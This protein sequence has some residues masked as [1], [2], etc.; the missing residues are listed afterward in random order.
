MK[1][2]SRPSLLVLLGAAAVIALA[3]IGPRWLP[4]PE[5]ASGQDEENVLDRQLRAVVQRLEKKQQVIAAL[6]GGRLSL[7]EAAA[8]F[9]EL[10]ETPSELPNHSYRILF[11]GKSDEERLCRQVI[12]WAYNEA[13]VS[14]PEGARAVRRRLEAELAEHLARHGTVVLPP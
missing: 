5:G 6:L 12:A 13:E 10:N 8:R 14:S 7:L 2:I 4:G 1:S 9:R 11:E 3:L